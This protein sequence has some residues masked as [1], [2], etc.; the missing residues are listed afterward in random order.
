MSN[1]GSVRTAPLAGPRPRDRSDIWMRFDYWWTFAAVGALTPFITL[2]YRELGLS[3]LQI[4]I[5]ASLP[6]LAV[7]MMAPIW[8]A[9][10][11]SFAIHR[12]VLRVALLVTTLL[13]IALTQVT[14]FVWILPIMA[15]LAF[16]NA[17]VPSL[18]DS[19]G[20]T[21]SERRSR[22]YGSLRVWGSLGYTAAV[23]VIGWL[24]GESVSS[25][26]LVAYA[27][28]LLLACVS[29]LGLPPLSERSTGP[30]WSGLSSVIRNRRML[31][32][33]ITSYLISTS[34]MVMY[35]FLG[36]HLSEL[37]GSAELIGTAFALNAISELPVIAFGAWFLSRLGSTR[38]LGL[39]IL[40]YVV[41]L[42]AYSLLPAPEWVLAVQ[43]L[44]GFSYGAFLMASVTLAHR[45]AGR[46]QAA[47][48]Q[49]LLTSMSFGF[50][51]IT[52]S[53]IGGALLDTIGTTGI[54]RLAAL[55]MLL[56]FAVYV[57]GARSFDLESADV[58]A[59]APAQA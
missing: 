10:A 25:L 42:V 13:A 50:G 47:T 27:A 22:S 48:A 17:P 24:M 5:L 59:K 56:T 51:S 46:E 3:G 23:W 57:V 35:S 55:V 15:A 53:L 1:A 44:H 54:F 39:A 58:E 12:L 6:P 41:R 45:L 26:F 29:T 49:G 9:I 31:V 18:T 32:L 16:V 52:G 40:V 7:A 11:D 30:V 43:L 38:L 37:G 34:A 4:G 14:S 8:G 20:M 33:L 19:Y 36:I 21:I 28:C 2:Y